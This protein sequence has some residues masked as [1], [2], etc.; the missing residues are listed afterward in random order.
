MRTPLNSI[1]GFTQVLELD[2]NLTEEQRDLVSEVL[3][4]GQHL[5]GLIGDVL[6]ISHAE[7][8]RLSLSIGQLDLSE[9]IEE[10]VSLVKLLAAERQIDMQPA[11]I[12]KNDGHR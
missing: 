8:G 7:S 3:R 10:S 5:L 1:L 4:A 11:L 12:S 6:D 9:V 2:E